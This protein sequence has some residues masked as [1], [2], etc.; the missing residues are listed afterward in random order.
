MAAALTD[1]L[2]GLAGVAPVFGRQKA[3][4]FKARWWLCSAARARADFGWEPRVPPEEGM[5]DT[6]RWYAAHGRLRLPRV[7]NSSV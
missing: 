4:E 7:A 5:V 2:A 6:A 3:I 1:E